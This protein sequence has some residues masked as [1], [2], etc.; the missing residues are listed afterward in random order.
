MI[1]RRKFFKKSLSVLL[2]MM[3]A[4][5]FSSP[6]SLADTIPSTNCKN[7]C[8]HLCINSCTRTCMASCITSCT[9]LCKGSCKGGAQH[10]NDSIKIKI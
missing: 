8:S 10:T 1:D 3:S 6:I 7:S 4:I 5:L 2:P 9:G